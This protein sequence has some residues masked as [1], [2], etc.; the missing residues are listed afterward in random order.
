MSTRSYVGIIED[1]QVKYGYH[2]CDSHLESLG[3]DLFKLIKTKKDAYEQ[4]NEFA[5]MDMG[6]TTSTESFF[7]IPSHDIFIEF[8]YGFNVK[9]CQWYVSSYHFADASKMHRLIDIVKDDEEMKVY[10]DMYMEQYRDGIIKEIR[11]NIK[12]DD[13]TDDKVDNDMRIVLFYRDKNW[14][15]RGYAN[16]IWLSIYPESKTYQKVVTMYED[17]GSNNVVEIKRKS[18]V[19]DMI[20]YLKVNN[21]KPRW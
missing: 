4:I 3:V 14:K 1:G 7:A 16:H 12:A 2:H 9:D 10:A 18:D 8:C 15:E 20:E 11:E 19:A 6:N 17:I 5:E 13:K 21:Y